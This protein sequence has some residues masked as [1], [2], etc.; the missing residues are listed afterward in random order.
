VVDSEGRPLVGS[1]RLLHRS[2]ALVFTPGGQIRPDGSF[3][4][5]GVVP[6]AYTLVVQGDRSVEI[7]TRTIDVSGDDIVGLHL[8]AARRS[9]ISGR[10]VL[11]PDATHSFDPTAV[12]ISSS[13]VDPDPVGGL[14]SGTI[15]PDLTFTVEARPGRMHVGLDAV[16]RGGNVG[17]TQRAIW[18]DGV[19]T[20]DNGIEIKPN[21][22][23]AGVEIELTDK[24]SSV[25]GA[26][27]D[28]RG[29]PLTD[30]SVV[31]FP[32]N[33]SLRT[34]LGRYFRL[35]RPD[36]AG[37]FKM[38]TLPAG[39]YLA[40]ALEAVDPADARDPDFLETLRGRASSFSLD[41]GE[42]KTLDLKLVPQP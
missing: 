40:I 4:I 27:T 3:A 38:T 39:E 6:G 25:T 20:L 7:A 33:R 24:I 12:F 19:D 32:R 30:Y 8:T 41:E 29:E 5:G 15:N 18:H 17:W 9:R 37:I 10:I 14:G 11:D 13:P 23:V 2:G 35:S 22:D 16:A 31:V 42:S 21:E 26:V 1:L 36:Q 34:T 28:A